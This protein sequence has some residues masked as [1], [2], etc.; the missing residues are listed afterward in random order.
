MEYRPLGRTGVVVSALSLGCWLF[1]DRVPAKLARRLVD[2]AID[3]GISFIDTADVYGGG[4][5]ERIV[6]RAL[7][8]S[9]KRIASWW[10]PKRTFPPIPVTRTHVA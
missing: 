2:A 9:G 8:A 4:E 6:G 5:S 3:S 1:G 10:R 7:Q